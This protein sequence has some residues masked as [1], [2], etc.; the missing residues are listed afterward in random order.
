MAELRDRESGK[1]ERLEEIR[2]AF[3]QSAVPAAQIDEEHAR[4]VRDPHMQEIGRIQGKK[5]YKPDWK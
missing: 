4:A 3:P 2:R 5:S 1:A